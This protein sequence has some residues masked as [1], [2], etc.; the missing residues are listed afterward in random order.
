MFILDTSTI[1]DY[2]RGNKGIIDRF[3]KTSFKI[4]YTTSVSKFELVYGLIQKPRVREAYGKQLQLLF[5]Q[6]GHLGFDD[7]CAEIAANIKYQLKCGGTPIGL[8]DVLIGAI[9]IHHSFT[10]VTSNVRH[11][12]KIEGLNLE[13]WK[14]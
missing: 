9:A 11:F 4:I 14:N 2:L 7:N 8:E 1:S 10:V 13:N 12:E 6:I 5:Q 3:R